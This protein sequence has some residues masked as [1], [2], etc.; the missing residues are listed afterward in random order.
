MHWGYERQNTGSLVNLLLLLGEG[1][2][3]KWDNSKTIKPELVSWNLLTLLIKKSQ[4]EWDFQKPVFSR[5]AFL[6]LAYAIYLYN[7]TEADQSMIF[8]ISNS[9]LIN[10]YLHYAESSNKVRWACSRIF[11]NSSWVPIEVGLFYMNRTVSMWT[12]GALQIYMKE[13]D[14]QWLLAHSTPR[15]QL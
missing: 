4:W 3:D 13:K 15:K 10:S 14:K 2:K 5:P 12:R 9:E 1:L 11:L 8:L 6:L 7:T